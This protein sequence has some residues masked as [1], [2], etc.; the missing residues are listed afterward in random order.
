MRGLFSAIHEHATELETRVAERTA[1]LKAAKD[2]VEAI[3]E[4]SSDGYALLNDAGV[5]TQANPSFQQLFGIDELPT[6]APTLIELVHPATRE[7]LTKALQAVRSHHSSPRLEL[8]CFR[9][10]GDIFD[11]DVAIAPLFDAAKSSQFFI[12]NVRDVTRQK[13]SERELR[14][15]LEKEKQ[16]NDLK[17]QFVAMVSHEFRTPL[18]IIQSSGEILGQYYERISEERRDELIA[19][20]QTQVHWLSEMLEDVMMI[21]KADTF[22]LVLELEKVDLNKICLEAVRDLSDSLGK[23]RAI[24]VHTLAEPLF[25][26]LDRALIRQVLTNVLANA[27][28]YSADESRIDVE[29]QATADSAIIKLCDQGIEFRRMILSGCLILSTAPKMS[30]RAPEPGWV[31][32]WSCGRCALIMAVSG[33]KVR[34]ALARSSL[35]RCRSDKRNQRADKT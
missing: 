16:L 8:V 7:A 23:N 33:W 29:I 28:K 24:E 21:A 34:L 31:W 4:H 22:G 3:L 30:G 14:S 2:H 1:E 20:I 9:G 13:T 12:C 26:E 18:T 19:R 5:I 10:D 27:V 6:N 32:Q 15:A 25:V 35:S 11:A 17:S